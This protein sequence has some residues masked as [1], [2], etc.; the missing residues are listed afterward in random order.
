M[1]DEYKPR[2]WG[3]RGMAVGGAA[4]TIGQLYAFQE[5]VF[6]RK[7]AEQLEQRVGRINDFHKGGIQA[8]RDDIQ[9]LRKEVVEMNTNV[10]ILM[11]EL[12]KK[13]ART[14]EHAKN[15]EEEKDYWRTKFEETEAER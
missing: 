8:V 10:A 12:K 1:A 14:E 15:V 9:G 2:G 4:L 3:V 13:N 6:T 11:Y 5:Y 7:E